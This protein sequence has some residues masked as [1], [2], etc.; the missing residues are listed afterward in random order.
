MHRTKTRWRP[1]C[2]HAESRWNVRVPNA[3]PATISAT[4]MS[5]PQPTVPLMT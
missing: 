4:P 5:A 1:G 2:D 3:I